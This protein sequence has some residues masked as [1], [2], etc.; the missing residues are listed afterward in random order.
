MRYTLNDLFNQALT[1]PTSFMLYGDGYQ[2][3]IANNIKISK[4]NHTNE[5]QILNMAILGNHYS[6]LTKEEEKYFLEN[7]WK[8]GMFTLS[9]SNYRIK[10]DTIEHSIRREVGSGKAVNKR[11]TDYKELRRV[12]LNKYSKVTKILNQINNNGNK[13]KTN[14]I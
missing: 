10:L 5:V 11:V 1:E 3:I 12:L 9:L 2:S 4:D 13:N 14:D 8:Y 6:L 7:G